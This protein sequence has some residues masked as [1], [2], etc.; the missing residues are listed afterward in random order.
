MLLLIKKG[1]KI[2]VVNLQGKVFMQPISCPF[3]KIDELAPK[4][5]KRK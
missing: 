2:A 5:K 3:L 1:V 4:L